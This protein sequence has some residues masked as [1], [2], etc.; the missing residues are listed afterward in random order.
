MRTVRE[1]LIAS[2]L[3]LPAC[4]SLTE[5]SGPPAVP[6]GQVSFIAPAGGENYQMGDTVQISWECALCQ[7]IPEGDFVRIG[8][9]DGA[10]VFLLATGGELTDN[11]SWEV[12]SASDSTTMQLPRTVPLLRVGSG[13]LTSTQ[14][15]G[16]R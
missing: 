2:T 15:A 1:F 3:A 9:Y 8:A 6:T 5:T 13:P 16:F 14:G 12:G 11:V 7:N 4:D 10:D